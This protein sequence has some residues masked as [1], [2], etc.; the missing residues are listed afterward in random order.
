MRNVTPTADVNLSTYGGGLRVT[1][2][3][4]LPNHG[5]VNCHPEALTNVLSTALTTDKFR[6][7]LD[8]AV[9]NAFY[10]HTLQKVMRFARD[11]VSNLY[12]HVPTVHAGPSKSEPPV[13]QQHLNTVEEN[14]KFQTP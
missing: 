10:V 9:D 3:G 1:Q 14:M 13:F 2:Q 6:V 8:S 7:M 5:M 4:E 12:T 11:M